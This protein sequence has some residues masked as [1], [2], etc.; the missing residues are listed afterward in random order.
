MHHL[1]SLSI[2]FLYV[3]GIVRLCDFS[4]RSHDYR[5]QLT[6][7]E[8]YRSCHVTFSNE[9]RLRIRGGINRGLRTTRTSMPPL[10]TT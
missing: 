5:R 6:R 1:I 10:R 4:V 2:F 8:N 9:D 7:S 3:R